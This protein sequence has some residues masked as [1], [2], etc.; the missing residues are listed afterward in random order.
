MG[1]ISLR[2][3]SGS[4]QRNIALEGTNGAAHVYI[5]DTGIPLDAV[6]FRDEPAG[7]VRTMT[8][9]TAQTAAITATYVRV[10]ADADCAIAVGTNPTAVF[11]TSF[12][13]MA[14]DV[15]IIKITSGDKIAAISG[16]AG[17]LYYHPVA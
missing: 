3:S 1:G 9:T 11:N 17:N 12:H 10:V 2:D 6:D 14:D 7:A 16:G 5:N 15:V 4:D 8:G 13:L